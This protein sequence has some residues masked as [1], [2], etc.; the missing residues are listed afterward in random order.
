MRQNSRLGAFGTTLSMTFGWQCLYGPCV[1]ILGLILFS[2]VSMDSDERPG[3]IAIVDDRP[4]VWKYAPGAGWSLWNLDGQPPQGTEPRAVALGATLLSRAS[5]NQVDSSSFLSRESWSMNS[6]LLGTNF[7]ERWFVIKEKVGDHDTI[8]LVSYSNHS[9][10]P[11]RYIG[12]KGSSATMP[13]LEERFQPLDATRSLFNEMGTNPAGG[14]HVSMLATA[15]PIY[16][17][18]VKQY[19]GLLSQNGL[20][21]INVDDGSSKQLISSSTLYTLA[22]S[23]NYEYERG[24][25]IYKRDPEGTA[26]F[27]RSTD[28]LYVIRNF[29]ISGEFAIPEALRERDFTAIQVKPKVIYYA[30]SDG[31]LTSAPYPNELLLCNTDGKILETHKVNQPP[32][33]KNGHPL[34]YLP[35]IVICP[36]PLIIPAILMSPEP[37]PFLRTSEKLKILWPAILLLSLCGVASAVGA[38][39]LA[40]RYSGAPAKWGW[41]VYV[42][43]FGLPGL[44]GYLMHYRHKRRPVVEPAT[45]LG[46]EVFA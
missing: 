15:P 20:Q 31:D 2:N 11:I 6:F 42:L 44:V 14:G 45:L 4:F 46:T 16:D 41:L 38:W 37:E 23:T 27:L 5:Q 33:I 24:G 29:E 12:T 19:L 9:R 22:S 10:R 21:S 7:T 3:S 28:T 32:Y 35:V 30:S 26:L 40:P 8:Y 17:T 18:S 1:T 34:W 36:S 13:P 25:V 39:K 43:I